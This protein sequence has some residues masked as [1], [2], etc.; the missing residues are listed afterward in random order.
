M[1]LGRDIKLPDKSPV[2][3]EVS[4]DWKKRQRYVNKCKEAAQKRQVHEYLAA[5]RERHNIS[6]KEKQLEINI[7][8][9][10][11]I[12]EDEKNQIKW[13]IRII[14]N[15]FVGKDNT[16]RSIRIRTGK[17]VIERP[18]QLLYPMDLYFDSKMTQHS[19]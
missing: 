2:E 18:I 7:D 3:D 8:N 19:R 12:K 1:I 14:E 6:H 11:M 5:L 9:V 17:K 16:I 15:I 13:K 10:V 4:G